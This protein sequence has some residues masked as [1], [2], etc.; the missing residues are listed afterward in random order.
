MYM[1]VALLLF[2]SLAIA[3]AFFWQK[4]LRRFEALFSLFSSEFDPN[5]VDI[6]GRQKYTRCAS[7]KWIMKNVVHGKYSRSG[8]ILSDFAGENTLLSTMVIGLAAGAV[9]VLFVFAIFQSSVLAGSSL[10]IVIAAVFVVRSPGDVGISY[11]LLS[12]LIDQESE[13]L[14]MGDFAYAQISSDRIM[15][16]VRSLLVIGVAS[17]IIAPWGELIPVAVAFSIAFLFEL[18]LTQV[19]LPVASVSLPLALILVISIV[20][21][22]AI[23]LYFAV[24]WK[25][26]QAKDA[27]WNASI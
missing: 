23:S 9:P 5:S 18:I 8:E 7:H 27:T 11:D 3:T 25:G 4:R 12:Y 15:R 14:D 13:D 21:L 17:L 1:T 19:F 10:V 20:P 6:S 16:W 22:I 26:K 2:S 24:K